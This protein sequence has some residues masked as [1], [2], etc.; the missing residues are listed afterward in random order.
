MPRD[1]PANSWISRAVQ[2]GQ[3]SRAHCPR[4]SRSLPRGSAG[5]PSGG[6]P[7]LACN[8][9][10]RA[11][12]HREHSRGDQARCFSF[13][14]DRLVVAPHRIAFHGDHC[15]G[16][17]NREGIVGRVPDLADV[18]RAIELVG[19]VRGTCAGPCRC[20]RCHPST[21]SAAPPCRWTWRA[22]R[23]ARGPLKRVEVHARPV[24]RIEIGAELVAMHLDVASASAAGPCAR[25][26]D[27]GPGR[28]AR[29]AA[30]C[31]AGAARL[32]DIDATRDRP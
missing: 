18:G 12:D 14:L 1:S 20:R 32:T 5:Q 17:V 19:E 13:A 22:R 10:G 11:S 26:T 4:P 23:P 6:R 29:A 8:D 28:S 24:V 16:I 7:C 2:L 25:R 30:S 31:A 21:P 15:L 3:L 27:S 9:A